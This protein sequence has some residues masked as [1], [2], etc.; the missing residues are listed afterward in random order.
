MLRKFNENRQGIVMIVGCL[1]M[2]FVM[3]II[4]VIFMLWFF[5]FGGMQT[6][7]TMCILFAVPLF[8]MVLA[9]ILAK[10]YLFGGKK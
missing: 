1:I 4:G 9:A 8:L 7:G 5:L 3:L 6:L 10:R 2:F